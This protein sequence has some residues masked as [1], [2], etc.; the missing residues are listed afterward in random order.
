MAL[1]EWALVS[2]EDAKNYLRYDDDDED[3]TIERMIHAATRQAERYTGRAFVR[4]TVTEEL[5][6]DGKAIL[7][8]NVWPLIS[9][10][11]VKVDGQAW[12]EGTRFEVLKGQARLR[13]LG[14]WPA[15]AR[16]EVAY[17]AGHVNSREEAEYEIPDVIQGV[18]LAIGN[19]FV[20]RED[21]LSSESISGQGST[22]WSAPK[23]SLALWRQ[24]R[25]LVV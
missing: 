4:R 20:R 7:R 18:L 13:A 22:S 23:E 14:V 2:L 12:N 11:S 3:K 16:I 17:V 24:Y 9:V 25:T 10:V 5:L 8:L 15:G 21:G 6:G 1:Q 19:W